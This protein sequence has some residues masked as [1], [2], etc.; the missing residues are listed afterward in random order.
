MQRTIAG[1]VFGA[2]PMAVLENGIVLMHVW[3]YWARAI[4]G[5]VVPVAILV[6]L[7]RRR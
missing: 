3:G 7:M 5:I 2:L 1:T 4:I 6:H